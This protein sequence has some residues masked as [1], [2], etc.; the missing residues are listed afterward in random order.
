[1]CI[2]YQQVQKLSEVELG[3]GLA[4]QPREAHKQEEIIAGGAIRLQIS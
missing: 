2:F 3:R 1:M 4:H